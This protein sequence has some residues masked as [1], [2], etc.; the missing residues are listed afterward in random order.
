MVGVVLSDHGWLSIQRAM[1]DWC[2]TLLMNGH[3]I[4]NLSTVINQYSKWY[5]RQ[6]P[7]VYVTLI[8]YVAT[9]KQAVKY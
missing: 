9:Q 6:L 5:N 4:N 1:T 8:S 3:L 2:V 7:C